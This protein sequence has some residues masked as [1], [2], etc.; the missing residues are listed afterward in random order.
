MRSP[1][2]GT[3]ISQ[4]KFR[5]WSELRVDSRPEFRAKDAKKPVVVCDPLEARALEDGGVVGQMR[6]TEAGEHTKP[7]VERP[8]EQS[9]ERTGRAVWRDAELRKEPQSAGVH[10]GCHPGEKV[11]KFGW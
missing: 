4:E 7:E 3:E 11:R 9:G 8:N 5:W 6:D 10:A 2:R 1:V